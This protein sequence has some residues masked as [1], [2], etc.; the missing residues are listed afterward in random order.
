MRRRLCLLVVG[1]LLSVLF[2]AVPASARVGFRLGASALIEG[3]DD[4]L[5]MDRETDFAI[6]VDGDIWFH[7][8]VAFNLG[9]LLG[10]DPDTMATDGYLGFRFRVPVMA[11]KMDMT[12]RVGPMVR[13]LFDYDEPGDGG[14]GVGGIL[15]VGVQVAT[16]SD[17]LFTIEFDVQSYKFIFPD[18]LSDADFQVGFTLL[19]GWKF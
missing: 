16:G 5:A 12:F 2:L 9:F 11:D 15:G 13:Y 8:A 17:S 19:V 7:D 18:T 3:E 4:I 10:I 14:V 1:A 6:G